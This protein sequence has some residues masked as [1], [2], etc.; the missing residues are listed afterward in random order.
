MGG[1]GKERADPKTDRG[2]ARAGKKETGGN[3]RSEHLS[4]GGLREE[5]GGGRGGLQ[6]VEKKPNGH[7]LRWSKKSGAQGVRTQR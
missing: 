3:P 7:H 5:K 2:G 4:S 1:G 6:S